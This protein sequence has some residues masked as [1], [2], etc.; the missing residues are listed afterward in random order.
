MAV[1]F[2]QCFCDN[3]S[4]LHLHLFHMRA[5]CK[6][7]CVGLVSKIL[8]YASSIDYDSGGREI[9][10]H[11]PHVYIAEDGTALEVKPTGTSA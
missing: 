6:A 1:H 8:H 11:P 10:I 9:L 2:K 5:C 3:L 4:L 7:G